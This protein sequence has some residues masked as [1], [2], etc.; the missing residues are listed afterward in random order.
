M[1]ILGIANDVEK[2]YNLKQTSKIN[3]HW[4]RLENIKLIEDNM[5]LMTP[6]DP[7]GTN[8]Q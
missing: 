5:T 4:K 6:G 1:G 8:Q 2:I 7:S 3:N